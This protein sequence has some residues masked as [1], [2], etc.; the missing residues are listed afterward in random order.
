MTGASAP[1]A[2]QV[3]YVSSY[4]HSV[5]KRECAAQLQS[6]SVSKVACLSVVVDMMD[7]HAG[8]QL[9]A[10]LYKKKNIADRRIKYKARNTV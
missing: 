7:G 3:C 4:V 1:E 5:L 6:S 8:P 9:G 2:I 10:K